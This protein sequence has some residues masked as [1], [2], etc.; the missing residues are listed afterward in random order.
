MEGNANKEVPVMK[1]GPN[2]TEHYKDG[3]YHLADA[4]K[5]ERYLLR[6]LKNN[7]TVFNKE[8]D[9]SW[10]KIIKTYEGTGKNRVEIK[11]LEIRIKG[12]GEIIVSENEDAK[13]RPSIEF[14]FTPDE[15]PVD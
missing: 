12:K 3:L 2:R 5:P 7:Q 14:V 1:E 6:I 4:D 11:E 13:R 9:G 15:I 8:Q 10:V